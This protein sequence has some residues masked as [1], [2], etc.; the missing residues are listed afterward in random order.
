MSIWWKKTIGIFTLFLL[1]V[2]NANSQDSDAYTLHFDTQRD[3]I[4]VSNNGY[5]ISILYSIQQLSFRH[6]SSDNDEYVKLEVPNH[7]S[8]TTPGEPELPIYTSLFV[9]PDDHNYSINISDIKYEEILLDEHG[10]INPIFPSQ[11]ETTK[12]STKSSENFLINKKTYLSD[13]YLEH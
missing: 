3:N 11:E 12:G 6:I 2:V 8:T 5:D 7:I 9:I 10:I 4:S 1:F 13:N